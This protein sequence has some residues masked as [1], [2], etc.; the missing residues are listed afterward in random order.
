MAHSIQLVPQDSPTTV[1]WPS[2]AA[3]SAELRRPRH[4]HA[5]PARASNL[6]V[7]GRAAPH[8]RSTSVERRRP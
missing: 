8:P 4:L 3:A 7:V 5:V 6:T 1:T 2:I